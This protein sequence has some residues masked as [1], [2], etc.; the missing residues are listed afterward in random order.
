MTKQEITEKFKTRFGPDLEV[1]ETGQ[2]ETYLYI[3]ESR[4]HE[5]CE[6]AK[7]DP[8][9]DFDY[10]F[11]FG[12]AHYPEERFEIV[13]CLSSH[14]KRHNAII[15]VKLD[16][17]NPETVTISD[18]WEAANWFE[19]EAMELFGI[20]FKN[21]PDPRPLLLVEDWDHGYPMRKGWTGPDF[22]PMPEE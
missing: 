2:P 1:L 16:K 10:L 9:L 19:R 14:E 15:K 17:D 6:F 5:L 11:N 18:V 3:S 21:H 7:N 20:K 13:L 22:I 8:D 12:G 4:Y